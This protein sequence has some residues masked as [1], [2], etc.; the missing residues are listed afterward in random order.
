M[1]RFLAALIRAIFSMLSAPFRLLGFGPRM[2]AAD[3]AAAALDGALD[4]APA[5]AEP[6]FTLGDLIGAHAE[7]RVYGAGPGAPEL[8]TLPALVATWLA[9]MDVATLRRVHTTPAKLLEAHVN[10]GADGQLK[11]LGVVVARPDVPAPDAMPAPRGIRGA[12]LNSVLAELGYG[13]V[14]HRARAR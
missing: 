13:P 14:A 1:G 9:G 2:T 7:R 3:L 6:S 10:A 4:E 11:S 12:D 5:D 8:G